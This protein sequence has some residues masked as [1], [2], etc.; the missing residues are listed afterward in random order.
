MQSTGRRVRFEVW[1]TGSTDRPDERIEGD[2]SRREANSLRDGMNAAGS[3]PRR[4]AAY[5]VKATT[6]RE[7][8]E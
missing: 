5:V 1:V 6:V 2:M 8:A 7:H 4:R 3:Q